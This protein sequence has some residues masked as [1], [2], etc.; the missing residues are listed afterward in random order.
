MTTDIVYNYVSV[1]RYI[2]NHPAEEFDATRVCSRYRS[3]PRILLQEREFLEM[4][5]GSQQALAPQQH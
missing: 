3:D 2:V 4:V 1:Y 5:S